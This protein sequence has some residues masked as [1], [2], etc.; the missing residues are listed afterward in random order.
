MRPQ[1]A[2]QGEP[3]LLDEELGRDDARQAD[4]GEGDHG[5]GFSKVGLVD[6]MVLQE[7]RLL[8]SGAPY[9]M[10]LL[11]LARLQRLKNVSNSAGSAGAPMVGGIRRWQK[12]GGSEVDNPAR[13]PEL[14]GKNP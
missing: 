13:S 3:E 11:Q 10:V 4:G 8:R 9:C 14:S 2:Q 5:H 6:F 12:D 7:R 1:G